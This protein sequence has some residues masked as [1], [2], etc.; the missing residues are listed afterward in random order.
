MTN[1]TKTLGCAMIAS[2]TLLA[3]CINTVPPTPSP[4]PTPS[5][6][7][8]WSIHAGRS[9]SACR[10]GRGCSDLGEYEL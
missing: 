3:G 8:T 5:V 1:R 4:T 2:V 6:T 7:S 9:R 10:D